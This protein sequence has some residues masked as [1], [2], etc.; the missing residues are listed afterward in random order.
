MCKKVSLALYNKVLIDERWT[1]K[2]EV[3]IPVHLADSG[4]MLSILINGQA[5]SC[6]LDTGSTFTLIPYKLW[7][8][9]NINDNKLDTSVTYNINSASHKNHNAVLG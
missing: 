1:K 9:R 2:P 8:K 4:P 3:D 5:T 6:I 7:K